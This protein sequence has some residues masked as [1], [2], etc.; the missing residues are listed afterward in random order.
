MTQQVAVLIDFEDLLAGAEDSLPGCID[1]V[2]YAAVEL[3]CRSYGNA[4]VRRAYADWARARFSRYQEGL[5]LNG[6]DLIH[7]TRFGIQHKNAVDIRLAIDAME[8]IFTRPDVG[9]FV[10][11]AGDGDYTP[12]A[13]RLRELGKQLIG[14]GT[15]VSANRRLVS[16]CSEY[17][18]WAT[19][20]AQVDPRAR[21]AVAAEF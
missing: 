7:I 8:L 6:V 20:V 17:R 15:Q 18:Y 1:P 9:V 13:Q 4:A 21:T 14:V 10:L 5:A 16:I 2:P 19:L 3:L 11:V 12:L